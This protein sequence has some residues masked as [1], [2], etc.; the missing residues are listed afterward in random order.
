LSLGDGRRDDRRRGPDVAR[1]AAA[2][3][4]FAD[5]A[6][7]VGPDDARLLGSRH[8]RHAAA[9]PYAAIADLDREFWDYG[10][11][12]FALGAVSPWLSMVDEKKYKAF[13]DRTQNLDITTI[14]SCHSP[15]IEGQFIEQAFTRVREL[16]SLESFALPDQSVLDQIIAATSEALT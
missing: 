11:A 14:A 9:D 6:W 12:L 8:L 4:R 13:V 5:H 16:P 3:L 1:A 15:V 7:S 10:R 2:G